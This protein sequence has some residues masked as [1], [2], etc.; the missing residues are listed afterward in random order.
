MKAGT[1]DGITEFDAWMFRDWWRHLKDRYQVRAQPPIISP[2]ASDGRVCR[3]PWPGASTITLDY[4][5]RY[6]YTDSKSESYD[7]A[8]P[9]K[10]IYVSDDDLAL[11]RRAQ[12]LSGGN[13]SAAIAGA[14]RRYVEF[15]EGRREGYD[16][17][18]LAIGHGGARRK[19][20]F[21]G[22]LLGEWTRTN[23]STGRI[24]LFR[25]YRTRK[26]KFV[27]FVDR[28]PEWTSGQGK[29]WLEEVTNWRVMLGLE[30]HS[31]GFVQGESTLEVFETLEQIRERVPSEFYDLIAGVAE[32]PAV[33]DLDI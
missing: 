27:L 17:I 6:T 11:F 19:Q 20:R 12:E 30:E 18:V 23:G 26:G 22:V 31:Y 28:S 29:N 2:A 5:Q 3:A 24:E 16:E 4:M 8:M 25:V 15:E 1:A 33:E 13:L 32:S 7:A 14:V 21:S 10:T 9:N